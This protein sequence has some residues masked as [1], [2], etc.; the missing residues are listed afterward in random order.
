MRKK[1][2]GSYQIAKCVFCGK[3]STIRNKQGIEV[4]KEHKNNEFQSIKCSCGSWLDLRAGKFGAYF[5][6]MNCGNISFR[7]GL[8]IK[9]M[10]G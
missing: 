5:N 4:C 6:C 10:M 9:E 3:T 1:V 2:Y 8:E 7:K